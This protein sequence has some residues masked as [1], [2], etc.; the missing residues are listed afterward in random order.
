MLK[1]VSKGYFCVLLL[2]GARCTLMVVFEAI[3]EVEAVD[4]IVNLHSVADSFNV[5]ACNL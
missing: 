4:V 1:L 3:V 5:G 2:P